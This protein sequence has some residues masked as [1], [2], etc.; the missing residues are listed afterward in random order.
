M[1]LPEGAIRLVVKSGLVR[2]REQ[3]PAANVLHH[4]PTA[5]GRRR[6]R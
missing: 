3:D 1:L 2:E 4:V 6:H 5:D